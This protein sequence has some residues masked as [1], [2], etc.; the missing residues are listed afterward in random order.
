MQDA[1]KLGGIVYCFKA[2]S[3]LILSVEGIESICLSEKH[4]SGTARLA[5]ETPDAYYE[6]IT[7]QKDRSPQLF[8]CYSKL[9]TNIP[10]GFIYLHV[11]DSIERWL[12][13]IGAAHLVPR[14]SECEKRLIDLVSGSP[15]ERL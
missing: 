2:L 7:P 8:V 10:G 15:A 3:E 6:F 13:R 5:P 14:L 12:L 4:N 9:R 11:K 1:D